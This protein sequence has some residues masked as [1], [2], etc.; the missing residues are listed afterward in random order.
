MCSDYV[1]GWEKEKGVGSFMHINA[2]RLS[3]VGMRVAEGLLQLILIVVGLLYIPR[4]SFVAVSGPFLGVPVS[5]CG[6]GLL[7]SWAVCT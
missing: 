1:M 6:K 5:L 2:E 4:S 3:K 7:P